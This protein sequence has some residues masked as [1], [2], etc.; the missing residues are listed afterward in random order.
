MAEELYVND[1]GTTLAAAITSTGATTISVSSSTGYP[2]TG[3]F[4]IL[5]DTELMLVTSVSG[6]T[7]T[8]TRGIES[9]TA[10][11][12]LNGVAVN[13]ILT[14]GALDAIR[15]N[16]NSSGTYASL[17][18]S[19]KSGDNYTP[20]DVTSN[21]NLLYTGSSW[22]S[23]LAIN[24]NVSLPPTASNWGWLNQG[25][26]TITD[27]ASGGLQLVS[28]S[29][30]AQLAGV[31]LAAFSTPYTITI[32]VTLIGIGPT[33]GMFFYNSGDGRLVLF[34]YSAVTSGGGGNLSTS[35]WTSF[36]AY[37]SNY[38]TGG[39]NYVTMVAP[40][41]FLRIK[42]DGTNLIYSYGADLN[43]FTQFDSRARHDWMAAGPTHFGIHFGCSTTNLPTVANVLHY[44]QS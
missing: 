26:A 38:V 15:I 37:S 16:M 18:S 32:G 28:R 35:K 40:M 5:V 21:Y 44:K 9:T 33:V 11:T 41:L 42:D 3:N 1:P 30:D 24:Q 22:Q 8:V 13:H 31:T 12:H 19:P 2:S 7:W 17:P 23:S 27:L 6:T 25:G 34:H 39:S 14:Q 43:T 20:S 4:R 29:A 36:T 10:A